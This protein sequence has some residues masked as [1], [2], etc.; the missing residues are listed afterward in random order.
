MKLDR[1]NL[2]NIHQERVKLPNAEIFNL[3]VKVLQFG[4]GVLLRGLPD[5]YI[6][7]AN[8]Q[9]KYNGRIVVVK[10]TD[11]GSTEEFDN[12]DSLYTICVRGIQNGES[13]SENIINSS[14]SKVL[15]AGKQWQDVLDIAS[16][17]SLETI[18][19]NTTEVGIQLVEDDVHAKPP[20]SFPGKLLAVLFH[21]YTMFNGAE[22]KGLVIVP[23]EL[24]VDN[25]TKLE[26]ILVKLARKNQLSE[27]FIK[28]MQNCNQFCNS[29]VD[30]IVPG[31][32]D[33]EKLSS[34][35]EELGYTDKLLTMSEV[36]SLWA[37]EGN[38]K[39]KE[40][41]SFAE[42]DNGVII[43]PD[44]NLHR[45]LKLRMLNGTHT[46][47]CGVAFL[48]GFETVK[49]A[50]DSPKMSDF[51]SSLMQKEIAPA[52]PY[53]ISEE[54]SVNFSNNVL[55]RFRNP[56]IKHLW[57]SITMNYTSKLKMRVIPVLLNYAEKFNAV[58]DLMAFGFAAYINFMKSELIDGKFYGKLNNQRYLINDDK[59]ADLQTHFN[60][61]P[62]D[63][64]VNVILS[65]TVLWGTNLT[66]LPGF[67]KSVSKYYKEINESSIQQVLNKLN[68]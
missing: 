45:E 64:I 11:Q 33:A 4:T 5:Y 19:S 15:V 39:V 27:A 58:P 60:N 67:A 1:N 20:V 12:Q 49:S 14:I 36:Y 62:E 63:K 40:K 53:E 44:I 29:L 42:V 22:D 68:F 34:L 41:L 28:W 50:M 65:D 8:R 56:Y 61:N 18:I 7:K 66:E 9:G 10:S 30:R 31:K 55:D 54:I 26:D 3:P 2:Q 43:T 24:I 47:S 6:D 35:Q 37:I 48:A 52:I 23:T 32:P 16:S 25:A 59:A 13:V 51:M 46:L 38:D 57:L 21:R 17:V